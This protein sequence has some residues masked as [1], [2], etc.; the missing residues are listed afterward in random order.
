MADPPEGP[1]T[2]WA[3][4]EGV[5]RAVRIRIGELACTSDLQSSKTV[6]RKRAKYRSL[7]LALREAG[8]N[9]VDTVHVVT[10]GVRGTVPLAN[11][12][13]LGCLGITTRKE[14]LPVQRAMAR[15]AI[16]HLNIIVRQWQET[17]RP[18]GKQERGRRG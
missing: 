12:A 11:R 5:R 13:E 18:K 16:K 3:S 2:H 8:W 14:Q 10:V 15:E 17:E 1:I 4:P 6:S 9:V 7:V